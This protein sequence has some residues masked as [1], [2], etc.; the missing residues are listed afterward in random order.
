MRIAEVAASVTPSCSDL[1][2]LQAT[3]LG[4]RS[5]RDGFPAGTPISLALDSIGIRRQFLAELI[6]PSTSSHTSH[7]I[8]GVVVS[9]QDYN[10]FGSIVLD[11]VAALAAA[12]SGLCPSLNEL[13]ANLA[14]DPRIGHVN[15]RNFEVTMRVLLS[16][17]F[18]K[19][20]HGP[21]LWV[22][23]VENLYHAATFR[24]PVDHDR[25]PGQN[26]PGA[27]LTIINEAPHDLFSTRDLTEKLNAGASS[28]DVSA[29]IDRGLQLLMHT[30]DIVQ[31]PHHVAEL[32]SHVTCCVWSAKGGPW[33]KPPLLNPLLQVLHVSAQPEGGFLKDLR[34]PE[35]PHAKFSHKSIKP[36][37]TVLQDLNLIQLSRRPF[38]EAAHPGQKVRRFDHVVVTDEARK[39]V[40]AWTGTPV[41]ALL[42]A[43]VYNPLRRALVMRRP[44]THSEHE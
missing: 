38:S 1:K 9:R 33:I 39:L 19:E 7:R 34:A 4:H 10:E 6:S 2:L 37:A 8:R 44:I 30:G 25:F 12:R 40:T 36:A 11:Y 42:N 16:A 17:Y 29:M 18:S 15:S 43:E 20:R 23:C 24:F 26:I 21:P 32:G 27:L 5:G 3:E 41:G 28:V 13:A 14:H 22:G 31:H 35:W